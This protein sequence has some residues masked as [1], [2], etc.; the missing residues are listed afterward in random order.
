MHLQL[1][2]VH[3][4]FF[5]ASPAIVFLDSVLSQPEP[6]KQKESSFVIPNTILLQRNG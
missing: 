5:N 6:K 4:H 3:K 2:H 1:T